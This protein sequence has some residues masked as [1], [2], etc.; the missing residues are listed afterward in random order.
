MQRWKKTTPI[1]SCKESVIFVCT[2]IAAAHIRS[3]Q[4]SKAA[5]AVSSGCSSTVCSIM[6]PITEGPHSRKASQFPVTKGLAVFNVRDGGQIIYEHLAITNLSRKVPEPSLPFST[7]PR[8]GESKREKE[9]GK[10]RNK[11]G[12]VYFTAFDYV[13]RNV[14]LSQS[15]VHPPNPRLNGC[16]VGNKPPS[17][18]PFLV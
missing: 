12:C 16:T 9:L 8:G 4:A 18:L 2:Y 11:P 7:W 1:Q 13:P 3:A 10:L 14:S 6:L 5:H 17:P 15:R